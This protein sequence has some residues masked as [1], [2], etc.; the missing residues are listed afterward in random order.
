MATACWLQKMLTTVAINTRIKLV[1]HLGVVRTIVGVTSGTSA[2]SASS[3]PGGISGGVVA[4][5]VVS[6]TAICK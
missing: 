3:G 5:V 6:S 2:I 1:H 4:S